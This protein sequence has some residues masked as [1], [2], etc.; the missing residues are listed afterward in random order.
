LIS[1]IPYVGTDIVEWIWGG[2]SVSNATL[3]R[4]FSLHYLLPFALAGLALVHL[5]A[6]HEHGSNNPVGVDGNIDKVPFH[7]YYTIKD[8]FGY[9]VFAIFFSLFIFFAPNYLGQ[10]WPFIYTN[11]RYNNAMCYM[12][13]PRIWAISPNHD[14]TIFISGSLLANPDLVKIYYGPISFKWLGLWNQQVTKIYYENNKTSRNLRDYTHTKNYIYTNTDKKCAKWTWTES[15]IPQSPKGGAPPKG[16]QSGRKARGFNQWLGGLIDGDGHF[17]VTEGKYTN[18]EI[19]VHITDEPLLRKI[20]NKFGGSIRKRTGVNALRWRVSAKDKMSHLVN[21][22]NGNIRNSVRINQFHRICGILGIDVLP[23]E[24][25]TLD[26]S[27]I[28][29]FFDADG[30]INYYHYL[31]NRPQLFISISNKYKENLDHLIR[32]FGGSILYDKGGHGSFKWVI[33]N[34]KFHMNFYNYHMSNP[35]YSLKGHKLFLIKEFYKLYNMK[36]YIK[37]DSCMLYKSWL[38]FDKKWQVFNVKR[39]PKKQIA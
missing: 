2:F 16:A 8:L 19:T 35:S 4:F 9:G 17:G 24:E 3:N 38:E 31:N 5:I 10:G 6:L 23:N 33:T 18:C 12:L 25:L 28:M 37:G 1:A 13:E 15:R 22:V 32:L 34:E 20:Q 7:P 14:N 27:W 11:L 26:N 29:G 21:S 39:I 30:T 36:A